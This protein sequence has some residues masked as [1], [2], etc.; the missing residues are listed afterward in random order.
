MYSS[1]WRS[2]VAL[3]FLACIALAFAFGCG[4]KTRVSSQWMS[5]D[6]K[7]GP[8]HKILV[9]GISE[10][11]LGRRTYEDSFTEA[12]RKGGAEAVSSYTLLPSDDKLTKEEIE[13]ILSREGFDGLIVTR[14][15]EVAEETTYVPPSTTVV[16]GG[17]RYGYYGHYGRNY[18]VVHSPGYTLTTEIVRLETQLWNAADSELA[19]GITSETF[20]PTSKDDAIASVTSVLVQKLVNDGLLAK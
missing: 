11:F 17:S 15:L 13:E 10:T 2:H 18:D 3:S 20:D 8:M 6:Y 5:P 14:L 7:G 9:L 19:W 4:T 1:S 12:L 16:S